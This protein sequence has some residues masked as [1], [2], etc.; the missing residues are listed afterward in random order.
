MTNRLHANPSRDSD[1]NPLNNPQYGLPVFTE[2]KS[3][4]LFQNLY[5]S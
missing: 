2:Q 3:T 5:Y 1:M 4:N